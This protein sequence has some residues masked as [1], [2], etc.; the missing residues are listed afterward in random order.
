[1]QADRTVSKAVDF[2][3]VVKEKKEHLRREK[4]MIKHLKKVNSFH[5]T[6]QL[7]EPETIY[8]GIN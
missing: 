5:H 6:T 3:H 1:M 4:V 7:H 8:R 2:M